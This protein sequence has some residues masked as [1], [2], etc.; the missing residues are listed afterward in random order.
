LRF[1]ER[2]NLLMADAIAAPSQF[3]GR[4][5]LD[6]LRLK[7][8]SFTTLH[9][10]VDTAQ[11]RPG[12]AARDPHEVLFVGTI[13]KQ[14]GVQE[15]F[16][17]RPRMV[18]AAPGTRFTLAGR[19]R[20]DAGHPCSPQVLLQTLSP[21]LRGRV[22]F[23][24]QVPQEELPLLY[25]RA[26][27]AVFPS[28]TEAFGLTCAEA[29]ACGAAVVMTLRGS[30]PELVERGRSGLLVEP[31]DAAGLASAVTRLLQGSELRQRL[32]AG[33]RARAI[34]KF[35]LDAAVARNIAFYEQ[36]VSRFPKRLTHA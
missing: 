30:G 11:F 8:R 16:E 7:G 10:G 26:A 9:H 5:T 3:I 4:S 12:A 25:S 1:L 24:G 19:Y 15:L 28:H 31:L 14:K 2:R 32:G 27:V 6:A 17:A 22:C 36:V 35:D 13:K 23:L 18:E 20:E 29:M 21:A 34:E 33:A